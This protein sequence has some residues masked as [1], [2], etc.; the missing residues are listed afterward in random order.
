MFF[1]EKVESNHLKLKPTE[2]KAQI[3]K[4]CVM[5]VISSNVITNFYLNM[6]CCGYNLIINF[7]QTLICIV[8]TKDDTV[9]QWSVES[10]D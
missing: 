10:E 5:K 8:E 4:S 3:M 1:T 7:N 2:N 6:P 9:R